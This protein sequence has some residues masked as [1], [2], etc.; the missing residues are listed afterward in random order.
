[1]TFATCRAV[2]SNDESRTVLSRKERPTEENSGGR[3][4]RHQP[5]RSAESIRWTESEAAHYRCRAWRIPGSQS[6]VREPG[7]RH[8][9]WAQSPG[10]DDSGGVRDRSY[11][12]EDGT[13]SVE[14]YRYRDGSRDVFKVVRDCGGE[15]YN[16]YFL[17]YGPTRITRLRR[18]R[19]KR[20]LPAHP[21]SGDCS[22]EQGRLQF[23]RSLAAKPPLKHSP[24]CC[25]PPGEYSYL[26][27]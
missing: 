8:N 21:I 18:S 3:S 17:H 25:S 12:P 5:A 27:F 14:E 6:L 10:K 20:A 2:I 26:S 15:G 4:A 9:F 7:E 24:S 23:D 1:M 22:K 19:V 13:T 16:E 11:A